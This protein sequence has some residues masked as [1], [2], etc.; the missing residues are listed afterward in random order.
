MISPLNRFAQVPWASILSAPGR[1]KFP[2]F[3]F[4]SFKLFD[5]P[6]NALLY[7]VFM[8][9]IPFI[10][11]YV[12]LYSILHLR[13]SLLERARQI[14]N[15]PKMIVIFLCHLVQQCWIF[16]CNKVQSL[17]RDIDLI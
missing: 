3:L 1:A 10:P 7:F 11:S 6:F 8:I 16:I 2:F 15:T 12:S 13:A 14:S 4:T 5:V 9:Y 17:S